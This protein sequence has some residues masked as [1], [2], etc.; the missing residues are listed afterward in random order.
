[1]SERRAADLAFAI[2]LAER[3]GRLLASRYE[4]VESIEL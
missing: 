4:R 3:A 1:M 2:A